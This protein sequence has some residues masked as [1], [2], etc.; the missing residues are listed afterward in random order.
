MEKFLK[1]VFTDYKVNNIEQG[2]FSGIL[3]LEQF[4]FGI[5]I[6]MFELPRP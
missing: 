3:N 5:E 6:W 4:Y 2:R 1:H